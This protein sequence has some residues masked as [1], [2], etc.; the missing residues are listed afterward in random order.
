MADIG[1]LEADRLD[2]IGV[3]GYRTMIYI[4]L[5]IKRYLKKNHYKYGG[6]S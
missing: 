5:R 6:W 4:V 2:L 1:K 3:V